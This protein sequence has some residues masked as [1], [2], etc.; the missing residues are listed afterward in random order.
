MTTC[1]NSIR[2][3]KT[4]LYIIFFSIL[5]NMIGE[6][7]L[8]PIIPLLILPIST[9]KVTPN[10]WSTADG[11][12]MLGWLSAAYPIAQFICAP[13]LGQISDRVGRK[14][15]LIL[16][17]TGSFAAFLLFAIGI[18]Y[19]NIPLLFFARII[20]GAT[21]GN[22]SVAQAVITDISSIERRAK[23]LGLI[24]AAFGLG[25]ILGPFIGGRLS[26]STS[27]SWF[28][29]TTPFYF[30]AF[31]TF[32]NI[33]WLMKFLPETIKERSQEPINYTRPFKNVAKAFTYPGLRSIIPALFLFTAGYAFFITFFAVVLVKKYEVTQAY[34][35]DY[36]AYFGIMIIVSQFLFS[37]YLSH[38]VTD[39]KVLR[40]SIFGTGICLWIYFFIP[41]AHPYLLYVVPPFLA[42]FYVLTFTFNTVVITRIMPSSIHG[43]SLGINSSAMAIAR[44]F[45]A[46]LSGYAATIHPT[47]TMLLGGLIIVLGG[48]YFTIMFKPNLSVN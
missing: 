16:S 41:A 11:F 45:P 36:F 4:V 1:S 17:T 20:D 42:S 27:V 23:N 34:V 14:K 31:L 15:A 30:V 6:G 7:V 18:I 22:V 32:V 47:F 26:D 9:F 2:D 21:G 40:Y 35:G 10:S 19:K 38:K 24:G 28:G 46:I 3:E 25:F 33:I 8:F 13:I 48:I 29:A 37:K 39:Y 44:A 5:T 12:I 43:E